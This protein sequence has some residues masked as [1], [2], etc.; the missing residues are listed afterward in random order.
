MRM[1]RWIDEHL[2]QGSSNGDEEKGQKL[3]S[4]GLEVNKHSDHVS[5]MDQTGWGPLRY[6]NE[7][8]TAHLEVL[9][10]LGISAAQQAPVPQ[11]QCGY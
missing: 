5:V 1:E 9:K 3:T 4:S 2:N 6:E 7:W 8:T 11:V 10:D